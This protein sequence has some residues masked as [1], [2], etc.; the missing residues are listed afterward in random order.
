VLELLPVAPV[1]LGAPPDPPDPSGFA[2]DGDP[3]SAL[4]A[5]AIAPKEQASIGDHMANLLGNDSADITG[6]RQRCDDRGTGP[7][8]FS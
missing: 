6:S 2:F 7:T 3:R 4:Q 5:S 1:P 8:H